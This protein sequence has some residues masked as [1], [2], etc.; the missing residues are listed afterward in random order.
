MDFQ[1]KTRHEAI[2]FL[3]FKKNH[4]I[5]SLCNIL[6]TSHEVP[7]LEHTNHNGLTSFLLLRL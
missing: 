6:L 1:K 4:E 7:T 2:I 5:V 3:R